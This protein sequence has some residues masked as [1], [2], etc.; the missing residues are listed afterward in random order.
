MS[1]ANDILKKIETGDTKAL[2]RAITMV[3][4]ELG[5]Y[6]E[7]LSS[8]KFKKDIPV[9]GFTGPPGAGKS[10]LIN[11]LLSFL[12]EKKKRVGVIA[13]DPSSPFNFG[14]LLGDRLRM[15]EHFN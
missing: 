2:A 15:A 14:S 7:I 8:L 9:I 1:S 5:G 4:N 10:T 3:E 13:I 6:E 11:A 12:S